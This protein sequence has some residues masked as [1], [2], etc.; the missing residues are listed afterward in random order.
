MNQTT[1]MPPATDASLQSTLLRI[2]LDFSLGIALFAIAFG[3]IS[4]GHGQAIAGPAGWTTT[5]TPANGLFGA[6]QALGHLSDRDA[7]LCVVALA[8]GAITA[9]NLS[10]ARHLRVI[11]LP[12]PAQRD[13]S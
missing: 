4:L 10:I 2:A 5:V 9:L 12:V 11:A 6:A 3:L 8:F 7:A 1:Q 13:N